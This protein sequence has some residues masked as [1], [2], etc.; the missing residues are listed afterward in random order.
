MF[1]FF[2]LNIIA[3]I[4]NIFFL[5][6]NRLVDRVATVLF[7]LNQWKVLFEQLNHRPIYELIIVL[8][9]WIIQ[10]PIGHDRPA[11]MIATKMKSTAIPAHAIDYIDVLI[12]HRRI[13]VSISSIILKIG[14]NI[15]IWI[16]FFLLNVLFKKNSLLSRLP[17]LTAD[18]F[19]HHRTCS[20]INL[21]IIINN[22]IWKRWQFQAST[23]NSTNYNQLW[24][25]FIRKE[26]NSTI[27]REKMPNEFR[28]F[29]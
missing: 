7:I 5:A 10:S 8:F 20:S 29:F 13:D 25:A 21:E 16:F 2:L 6:F 4:P 9:V 18:S 28:F 22:L 15:F 19:Q 1:I 27:K 3:K 12:A 11:P 14:L 17:S 24:I 26:T 23:F